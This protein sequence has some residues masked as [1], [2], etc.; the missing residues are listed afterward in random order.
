MLDW[1]EFYMQQ[2]KNPQCSASE[3]YQTAQHSLT[4]EEIS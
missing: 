3:A 4:S 2:K 1:R